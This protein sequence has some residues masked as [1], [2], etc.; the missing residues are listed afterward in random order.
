VTTLSLL[1]GGE[2]LALSPGHFTP[3]EVAPGTHWIGGC[4]GPR[5]GLDSVVKRKY[6]CLSQESNTGRPA[7]VTAQ[8]AGTSKEI[9]SICKRKI[10]K[11]ILF[12]YIDKL[13][14]KYPCV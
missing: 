5:A 1:D 13:K 6:L 2:W 9:R 14:L 4:V 12:N 8:D 10:F 7:R 3:R 11:N